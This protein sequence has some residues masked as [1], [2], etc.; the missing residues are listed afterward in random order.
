[1]ATAESVSPGLGPIATATAEEMECVLKWLSEPGARLVE[2]DGT[3]HSPAF[4]AGRLADWLS[5]AE[6]GRE[7]AGPFDDRRGLR[8]VHRPARAAV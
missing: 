6:T 3:W 5:T 4:G 2:L 8:P 7:S 1:V